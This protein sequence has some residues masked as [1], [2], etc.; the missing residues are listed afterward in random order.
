MYLIK[1]KNE[2]KRV[3]QKKSNTNSL[4]NEPEVNYHQTLKRFNSFEELNEAEAKEMANISP[5]NHLQNATMLIR[6]VFAEQL[7]KS[8][9]KKVIIM[10]KK[11]THDK[12]NIMYREALPS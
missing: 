11:N 10:S 8:M 2:M 3:L 6:K 12:K 9:N 1:K 4:D 5:T 7:K